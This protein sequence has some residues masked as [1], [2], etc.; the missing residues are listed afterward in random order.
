MALRGSPVWPPSRARVPGVCGRGWGHPEARWSQEAWG[1]QAL[2]QLHQAT[3]CTATSTPRRPQHT[4][5][6]SLDSALSCL[7]TF[8]P[9]GWARG[10]RLP[11]RK[12]WPRRPQLLPAASPRRPGPTAQS[13]GR[14]DLGG[15]A[16][17]Q[18]P[19]GSH[20]PLGPSPG[21]RRVPT[22]AHASARRPQPGPASPTARTGVTHGAGTPP[23]APPRAAALNTAP[24]QT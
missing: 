13:G 20:A 7:P 1:R 3:P 23:Q 22:P 4:D 24:A 16:P 8:P 17:P 14:R 21:P 15:L 5:P 2:G 11:L 12:L 19:G 9:V 6:Q 18:R 10:Q